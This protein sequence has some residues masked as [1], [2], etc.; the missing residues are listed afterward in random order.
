MSDLATLIAHLPPEQQ[1]IRAKCF[2]PS[3]TFI[4]F[5]EEEIEQSIPDRFE[6]IVRLYPHRLAVKAG[7]QALPYTSLNQAANRLARALLARRALGNETVALLFEH[8]V[9]V[10]TAI[11]GTL[12]A[13]K[14]FLMLDPAFPVE[15]ITY[16]LEEGQAGCIVTNTRHMALA[17]QFT[18]ASR[19]VCNIDALDDALSTANVGL[20]LSP[21]TLGYL[22]YTSGSTGKPKGVAQN[23]RNILHSTMRRTNAFR[24]CP[25]D[26]LTL[27]SSG[28]L[29]AVT[30]IFSTL[31][32]GAGLYPFNVKEAGIPQLI[33][34]L[35]Q[36]EITIYH[37]SASLFRQVV[38][39]LTGEEDFS[40]IR[41]I[42]SAS[43]TGTKGDVELYR[44]YFSADCLFTNGLSSTETGTSSLYFVDKDTPITA[45]TVPLGYPLQDMEILVLDEDG[46]EVG[47]NRVGEIAVRSRYLALGYWRQPDLTEARFRP[48]PGGGD[49]RIYLTGDVGRRSQ[50][51]CLEHL[52]RKDFQVKVRGYRVET[53]DVEA[54]LIDHPGIKQVVVIGRG[55]RS[56]DMQLLAYVV[57]AAQPGPSISGLRGFLQEKLP[58]YMIPSAFVMLEQMPLTPNGKVDRSAL[59][60]LRTSRPALPTPFLAPRTPA[61]QEL[62]HIWSEVLCLDRVGIHDNFFDLGGHSLAAARIITRVIQTLQLELAIKALFDA[63]TVADMAS[64][65]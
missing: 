48:D 63:P 40:R 1:A 21:E 24:I 22:L 14:L 2:H 55:T 9:D 25:A 29:Q 30:N 52:G 19:H 32:T 20:A 39:A 13:G 33:A 36:E 38:N 12:K 8:S 57:P 60:A 28:T 15:R 27:L 49:H 42:R 45:D 53:A 3:G 18:N 26:R 59:P 46:R 4:E 56:G 37:S 16:M 6:K 31:L 51:G 64:P 17:A 41:L 11:V 34:W 62:A 58:D 47:C 54:K 50:D 7:K 61:E 10:I 44:R 5:K 35:T 23:H 65:V 43:E